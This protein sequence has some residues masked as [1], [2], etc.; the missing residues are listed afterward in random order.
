LFPAGG[1]TG[2]PRGTTVLA[3]A[4]PA[5]PTSGEPVP[6]TIDHWRAGDIE[7]TC[8]ADA[9]AYAVIS[10]SSARGWSAFVDHSDAPWLTADV[11]RRPVALPSGAH[12][13]RWPYA[14]PALTVG[15]STAL[16]GLLGLLAIALAGYRRSH[17]API[18]S[19]EIA[20]GEIVTGEIVN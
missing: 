16:A 2:V 6:C 3:G 4:G 8:R 18:V 17:S 7:L 11:R 5:G 12:T 10:S 13:V 1:G 14:A 9:P 20:P 15:A 19:E